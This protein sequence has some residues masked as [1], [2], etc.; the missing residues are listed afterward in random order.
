MPKLFI[1][2]FA[3]P[4]DLEALATAVSQA[5][6]SDVLLGDLSP[7]EQ[8]SL[9]DVERVAG[10]F[11]VF[12]RGNLGRGNLPG[13]KDTWARV[14]AGDVMLLATEGRYRY[15]FRILATVTEKL[16]DRMLEGA[17]R[18]RSVGS[19]AF[20]ISEPE[21]V[22]R[23]IMSSIATT[24]GPGNALGEVP[25]AAIRALEN[26]HGSL[27][28][29]LRDAVG[30]ER[31][32]SCSVPTEE[33]VPPLKES[34]RKGSKSAAAKQESVGHRRSRAQRA[35]HREKEAPSIAPP[36]GSGSRSRIGFRRTAP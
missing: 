29:F 33:V 9:W 16:A 17:D 15:G 34:P 2:P 25:E 5:I 6:P 36:C 27:D 35:A 19:P 20:L 24:A 3:S 26:S 7:P 22:D 13:R 28:A 18:K 4:A 1:L 32:A 23:A 31:T 11:Y 10:D 12:G 14:S 8:A 30:A 21:V